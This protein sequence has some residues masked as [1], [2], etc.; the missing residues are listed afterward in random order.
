M[1]FGCNDARSP[2]AHPTPIKNQ[3]GF[4]EFN[5]E[6]FEHLV[7]HVEIT[8]LMGYRWRLEGDDARTSQLI[9][10]LSEIGAPCDDGTTGRAAWP[11]Y[12]VRFF[13][14]DHTEVQFGIVRFSN[15]DNADSIELVANV[16]EF[17][18]F[19]LK[20]GERGLV[21]RGLTQMLNQENPSAP[22]LLPVVEAKANKVE[23]A[24]NSQPNGADR[25]I[26]GDD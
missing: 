3:K 7:S 6:E 25:L 19:F 21:S 24:L 16:G 15:N 26:E 10:W 13:F 9:S 11:F 4:N 8:E 14:K 22:V 18:S 20:A 1:N 17:E 2:Q 5:F 23:G 12:H